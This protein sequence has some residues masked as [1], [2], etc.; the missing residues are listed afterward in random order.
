MKIE[1]RRDINKGKEKINKEY[2]YNL[3][4]GKTKRTNV[5]PF[6]LNITLFHILDIDVTILQMG[7]INP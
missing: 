5:L 6:P 7:I 4:R 1:T 2:V 3:Q